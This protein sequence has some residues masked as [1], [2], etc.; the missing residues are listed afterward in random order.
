ML[1]FFGMGTGLFE[2][3]AGRSRLTRNLIAATPLAVAAYLYFAEGRIWFWGYAI[4]VILLGA[5]MFIKDE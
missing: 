2:W 4:G 1:G 3:W 5:D